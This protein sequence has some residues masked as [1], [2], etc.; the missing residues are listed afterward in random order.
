VQAVTNSSEY[1]RKSKTRVCKGWQ[2]A[3]I[4]ERRRNAEAATYNKIR[5]RRC[6]EDGQIIIEGLFVSRLDCIRI[7][8]VSSVRSII[9]FVES[10]KIE[11]RGSC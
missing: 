10:W 3:W 8:A 2:N 5:R 4:I 7:A 9:I 1:K 11:I 6:E